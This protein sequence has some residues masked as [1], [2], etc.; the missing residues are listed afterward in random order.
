MSVWCILV[1]ERHGR[2]IG[3]RW[4]KKWEAIGIIRDRI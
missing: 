1:S 4:V 3:E 2:K